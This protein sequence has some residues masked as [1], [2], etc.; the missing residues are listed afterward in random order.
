V[1][2]KPFAHSVPA[3]ASHEAPLHLRH[4]AVRL[5]PARRA[6]AEAD[7]LESGTGNDTLARGRGEYRFVFAPSFGQDIILDF[8][9]RSAGGQD[10]LVLQGFGPAPAVTFTVKCAV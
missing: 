4:A 2:E 5:H 1:T 7:I 3:V 6:A 9:A 10:L 8:D